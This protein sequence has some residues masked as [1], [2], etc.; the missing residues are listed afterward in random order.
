GSSRGRCR[1]R[2][3]R[4]VSGTRDGRQRRQVEPFSRDRSD[5]GSMTVLLSGDESLAEDEVY[6]FISAEPVKLK[7]NEEVRQRVAR[8]LFHEYGIAVRDME[9]DFPIRVAVTG[10]RRATRK[11]DI[12]IFEHGTPHTMEKL[13]RVVICKPEPKNGR[14]VT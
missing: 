8:A 12:A 2:G 5:T 3:P 11:A 4:G 9:R 1:D 10:Q 14:A 7:G 13:R 6:D